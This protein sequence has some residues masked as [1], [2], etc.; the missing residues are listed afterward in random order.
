ML[1]AEYTHLTA[2]GR[3]ISLKTSMRAMPLEF[4]QD[5]PIHVALQTGD[6]R[7]DFPIPKDRQIDQKLHPNQ[8]SQTIATT[9]RQTLITSSVH[10]PSS[11]ETEGYDVESES[12]DFI[13]CS[14]HSAISISH[15]LSLSHSLTH[16]ES[17]NSLKTPPQTHSTPSSS[18]PFQSTPSFPPFQPFARS[19]HTHQHLLSTTQQQS[20]G[21]LRGPWPPCGLLFCI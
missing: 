9:N 10:P 2:S 17:R 3:R 12:G 5:Q 15:S 19:S 14:I 7:F 6:E 11:H 8:H 18:P 4:T 13:P 20:H 21:R 1:D 16:I